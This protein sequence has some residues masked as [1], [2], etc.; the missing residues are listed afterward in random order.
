MVNAKQT[1]DVYC[2]LCQ[3]SNNERW[4]VKEANRSIILLRV[5]KFFHSLQHKTTFLSLAT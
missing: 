4:H 3:L 5:V 1:S 2:F